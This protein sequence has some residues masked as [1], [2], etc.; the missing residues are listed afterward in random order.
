MP[1]AGI[2][3]STDHNFLSIAQNAYCSWDINLQCS[4][5]HRSVKLGAKRNSS[6]CDWSKIKRA[7]L[8]MEYCF[9]HELVKEELGT[10]R[11]SRYCFRYC[12]SENSSSVC[13]KLS[14]PLTN[15]WICIDYLLQRN[16][17]S[18]VSS[19]H[20]RNQNICIHNVDN[21]KSCIWT[22]GCIEMKFEV[23]DPRSY[24]LIC[25]NEKGLKSQRNKNNPITSSLRRKFAL[26]SKK[27]IRKRKS[28]PCT[29][30][31]C[32]VLFCNI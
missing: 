7:F 11:P 13:Y 21:W 10:H 4:Q 22:A 20:K 30:F 25:N 15:V 12:F 31:F 27:I 2:T 8:R 5:N 24:L 19:R 1:F 17:L 28:K 23:W 14:Q 3:I 6:G 26:C 18:W 16:C 9:A 29:V 32:F